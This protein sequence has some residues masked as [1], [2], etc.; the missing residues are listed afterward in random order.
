MGHNCEGFAV[1][2]D[3]ALV[4]RSHEEVFGFNALKAG[5]GFGFCAVLAM[6]QGLRGA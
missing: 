5:S 1:P 2:I 3:L 6:R 4:V